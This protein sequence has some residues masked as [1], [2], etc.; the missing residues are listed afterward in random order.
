MQN[1]LVFF[2][3]QV[4]I[5]AEPAVEGNLRPEFMYHTPSQEGYMTAG[6]TTVYGF[7]EG[8]EVVEYGGFGV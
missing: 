4:R 1:V 3:C 7:F 8:F 6:N 5:A 2:I